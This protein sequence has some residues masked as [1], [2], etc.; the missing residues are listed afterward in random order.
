MSST[1]TLP[2]TPTKEEVNIP[3]LLTS[4]SNS[5]PSNIGINVIP[6]N[7]SEIQEN[8]AIPPSFIILP[9]FLLLTYLSLYIVRPID[10][11][12]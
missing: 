5:I 7:T 12:M 11:K 2:R 4:L 8:I 6:P 10:Q 1:S 9:N 3:I